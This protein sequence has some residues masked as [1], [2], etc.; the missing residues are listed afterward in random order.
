[1]SLIWQ[2]KLHEV[3]VL[4]EKEFQLNTLIRVLHL[5]RCST[6]CTS[7]ICPG[8]NGLG[9][10]RLALKVH[11]S[12]V[13]KFQELF[14]G[15]KNMTKESEVILKI[16]WVYI[17]NI[18]INGANITPYSCYH[19]TIDIVFNMLICAT[20]LNNS[21]TVDCNR[22]HNVSLVTKPESQVTNQT[23]LFLFH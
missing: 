6:D 14:Y 23:S 22:S 13:V 16:F 9:A 2:C 4:L 10:K 19:I 18:F 5:Q 21:L 3:V 15:L 17:F 20:R 1:M 12:P 7:A 8:S 11:L